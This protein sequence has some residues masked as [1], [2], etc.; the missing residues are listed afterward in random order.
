MTR[1]ARSRILI[2]VFAALLASCAVAQQ[3]G[4]DGGY[5]NYGGDGG[6]GNYGDGRYPSYQDYA[7]GQQ[8]DDLYANYAADHAKGMKPRG[9]N[10]GGVAKLAIA[11][12]GGWVGAKLHTALQRKRSGG[13]PPKLRL[14]VGQR[15]LCH[16]GLDQWAKGTIVR[17]WAE[18]GEGQYAPYQIRLD[19]GKHMIYA[20][21]DTNDVIRAA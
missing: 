20:P 14:R 9:G 3:A 18:Q 1:R 16:M 5:G 10:M 4:G 11:G 2:V 12:M 6:Y 7:S 13:A 8:Q 21:A 17:L 15:V 19:D